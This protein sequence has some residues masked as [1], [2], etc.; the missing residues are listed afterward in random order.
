ML[1]ALKMIFLL[2]PHRFPNEK[3]REW[4]CD[5]VMNPD[6]DG[7]FCWAQPLSQYI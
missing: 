5:K 1:K 4:P 6:R 2:Q 7:P 3:E